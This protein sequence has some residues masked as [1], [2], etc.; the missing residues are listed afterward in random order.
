MTATIHLTHEPETVDFPASHYVFIE[1]VGH[2]P[3]IAPQAWHTV[4]PLA[5]QLMPKNQVTGAAALYKPAQG[6][7]RAGFMLAAPPVD[8]P[9]EL[10]Y[11]KLNGGK[12]VRF[13]LTGPF[14]HLP[15]ATSRAFGI[16]A[17]KKISLRDDFNI[18][19]YLTDPRTTLADQNVTAILFPI[20]LRP[21]LKAGFRIEKRAALAQ[22]DSIGFVCQAPWG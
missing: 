10:S 19:H 1:R 11:A 7:Y 4:E 9:A 16:V 3:T 2:I 21:P 14:D 18:E 20:S 15:E 6:V 17:E 5:A 22:D 8:L 12:Y 13:T